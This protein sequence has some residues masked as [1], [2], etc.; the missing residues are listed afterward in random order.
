MA[1]MDLRPT[2]K[3]ILL[4][5]GLVSVAELAAV[6]WWLDR[7]DT[8]SVAAW[9][10]V[11]LLY[12]LP[13]IKHIERQ[14]IRCRL[15]GG[16]LRYEE[17]VFS[18]TVRTMPAAKIQ[19]VTVRRSLGQRMWGVGNVRIETAGE[20]SALEIADVDDPETVAQTILAAA[21]SGK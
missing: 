20:S 8:L 9:M 16:H 13:I 2:M 17:G 12:L 3:F 21:A 5:Y 11:T 15:T 4:R 1:E 10:A 14:R 7:R 19:D 18:T 6:V